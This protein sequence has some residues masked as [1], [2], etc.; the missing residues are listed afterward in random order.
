MAI[1][2]INGVDYSGNVMVGSYSVNYQDVYSTWTDANGIDHRQIIRKKVSGSFDM[3]FRN[4]TSYDSF[5]SHMEASKTAGGWIPC[6]LYV[7]NL[8][9]QRSC[10]LY[11]SYEP[12]LDRQYNNSRNYVPAFTVTIEEI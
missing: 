11:M 10:K 1:L 5:I 6:Y 4:K 8:N 7:T 9:Q 3:M 12:C 2:N